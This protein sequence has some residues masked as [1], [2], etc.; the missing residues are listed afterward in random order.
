[1]TNGSA[2]FSWFCHNQAT[3]RGTLFYILHDSVLLLEQKDVPACTISPIF[4][5]IS[6]RI[7]PRIYV[8]RCSASRDIK[9]QLFTT[10][11]Q[12][13]CGIKNMRKADVATLIA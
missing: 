10:K 8:P 13:F 1:M 11:K 2:L 6:V 9:I 3:C 12:G 7:A 4:L 5:P